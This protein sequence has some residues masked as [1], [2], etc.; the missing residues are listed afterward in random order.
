M[1]GNPKLS[2][3]N[4]K[5]GYDR[6][7][8]VEQTDFKHGTLIIRHT[9]YQGVTH[10]VIYTDFL[11]AYS[12][13]GADTRVQL[14]E[15][16]DYEVALDYEICDSSGIDSYTNYRMYFKFKI[17]N[18]N[19]MAFVFNNDSPAKILKDGERSA[20]GIR[21][22]LANSHYLN[23][24]VKEYEVRNGVSGYTYN[25]VRD[26]IANDGEIYQNQ[27]KYEITVTNRY[28]LNGGI[29]L[30]IYVGDD[31]I[32]RALEIYRGDI[33][34]I[35]DL[36]NQGYELGDDGTLTAPIPE[37]EEVIDDEP[38][39]TA[40]TIP[41]D[42][43]SNIE[44]TNETVRESEDVIL[45]ET[46]QEP[47]EIESEP[48]GEKKGFNLLLIIVIAIVIVFVIWL[49]VSKNKKD[50]DGV[51]KD[52]PNVRKSSTSNTLNKPETKL[53]VNEVTKDT[54]IRSDDSKE[55]LDESGVRPEEMDEIRHGTVNENDNIDGRSGS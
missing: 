45:E 41:V 27:G 4:D 26:V 24:Q 40:E 16:G 38:V 28:Q 18:G 22:D 2:I 11:A 48:S 14:F 53:A 52:N 43:L 21:I 55:E 33:E 42:E 5:N 20:S 46:T 17:R 49:L 44:D 32:I 47:D 7:F 30:V 36:I 10:D 25:L 6:Q 13:T 15:E 23:V 8:Q 34:R 3:A 50:D 35:S 31:P 37:E 29:T 51:K 9:D 1:N 39:E 54:E 12:R 19:N